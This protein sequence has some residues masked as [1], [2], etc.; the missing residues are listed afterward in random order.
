[1]ETN[2]TVSFQGALRTLLDTPPC[3]YENIYII[4]FTINALQKSYPLIIILLLIVFIL[5]YDF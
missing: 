3:I 5:G 4:I 1:M 2:G